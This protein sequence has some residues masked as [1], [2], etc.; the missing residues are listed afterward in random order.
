[1][2]LDL[3][4]YNSDCHSLTGITWK[5]SLLAHAMFFQNFMHPLCGLLAIILQLSEAL[6]SD[7]MVL[8]N[9]GYEPTHLFAQICKRGACFIPSFCDLRGSTVHQGLLHSVLLGLLLV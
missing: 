4:C 2:K 6:A 3:F 7:F 9:S 5:F 8:P 1:M